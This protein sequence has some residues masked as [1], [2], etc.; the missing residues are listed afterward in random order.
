MH[1]IGMHAESVCK[2]KALHAA[3]CLMRVYPP[4]CSGLKDQYVNLLEKNPPSLLHPMQ[5]SAWYPRR[6]QHACLPQHAFTT[7]VSHRSIVTE[8]QQRH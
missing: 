4:H 2:P 5:N 1:A 7:H 6:F 8:E 3:A